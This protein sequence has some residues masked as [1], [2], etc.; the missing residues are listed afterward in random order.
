MKKF[1][2]ACLF[3]TLLLSGCLSPENDRLTVTPLGIKAGEE[4]FAEINDQDI[5]AFHLEGKLSK[6]Y[7]LRWVEFLPNHKE[8]T[9]F[10]MEINPKTYDST[11][12]VLQSSSAKY[13]HFGAN[14]E[15]TSMRGHDV[16]K[17]KPDAFSSEHLND[18]ITLSH[19]HVLLLRQLSVNNELRTY[20]IKDIYGPGD[21]DVKKG[22]QIFALVLSPL[23]T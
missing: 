18:E 13:I 11:L 22:E 14:L 2:I 4:A 5:A 15:G 19:Y 17:R 16:L 1:G 8:R 21:I 12:R 6:A 3:A 23:D 9:L 10:S 7:L 20:S